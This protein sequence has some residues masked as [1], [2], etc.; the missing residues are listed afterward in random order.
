MHVVKDEE[1]ENTEQMVAPRLIIFLDGKDIVPVKKELADAGVNF[2]KIEAKPLSIMIANEF[3]L[4]IQPYDGQV[5]YSKAT[6]EFLKENKSLVNA[7]VAKK[8]QHA[9]RARKQFK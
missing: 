1:N 3:T 7:S 6:I 5:Y 4:K 8:K 9:R 2:E